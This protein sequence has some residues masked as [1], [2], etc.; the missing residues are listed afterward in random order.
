MA[1]TIEPLTPA[2]GAIVSGM[3]LSQPL[4]DAARSA[5]MAALLD[6]Q[7]I[8]FRDQTLT[9]TQQRDL[10]AGFGPLHI[11]PI[12]PRSADVPEIMLL[13]TALNDL[14][15][16]ALWHSD[17]SFSETP[18][19]G[20]VLL[21]RKI[22][23]LGGDTLWASASAAY[24]ALPAALQ[25]YLGTLSAIHDL[26]KSFPAD[27]FGAD[28]QAS[29]QLERA[30]R[31]NPPVVH[32]VIRTHPQT[33]KKAIYVSEGFTTG[34]VGMDPTMAEPLLAML[35][36]HITRPEFTV[37]W[38]WRVGDVAIWDNR[39]TQHYAVYDYGDGHRVMNRA[40]IIGDRPV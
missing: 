5:I 10:A 40:T 35:Y 9:E 12:Y 22:P 1:M 32:P 3:D 34:I 29:E 25:D 14:R 6:R 27:R 31:N 33:G 8:F 38:K 16:N 26:A 13:D 11:H 36:A 23:P 28:P 18:S 15:D 39:P 19:L 17:I 4:D 30:K 7:V 24:D 21:A 37:R 20:A 2:I